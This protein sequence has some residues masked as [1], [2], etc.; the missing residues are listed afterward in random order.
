MRVCLLQL[1]FYFSA[2]VLASYFSSRRM[3]AVLLWSGVWAILTKLAGNTLLL[4]LT[5]L[6]AIPLA[7][8]IMYLVNLAYLLFV[9]YKHPT[10]PA[11]A[12]PLSSKQYSPQ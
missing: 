6:Y 1:P 4:P 10:S 3:Y 12:G 5:G 11:S 9:F 2:I 7:T 8:A